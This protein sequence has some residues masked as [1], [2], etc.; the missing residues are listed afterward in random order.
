MLHILKSWPQFFEATLQKRK[1]FELRKNDR[2]YR[3]GDVLRMME[4]KLSDREYSG[5]SIEARVVYIL[6][7]VPGFGLA[8]DHVILGIEM[9]ETKAGN[10]ALEESAQE[11]R[12]TQ[13]SHTM[14]EVKP[15]TTQNTPTA[16]PAQPQPAQKPEVS[17]EIEAKAKELYA[18]IHGSPRWEA[19]EGNKAEFYEKAKQALGSKSGN[20]QGQSQEQPQK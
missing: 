4:Y 15:M 5:R 12:Y 8:M 16:Q 3:V 19:F 7:G 20:P 2:D 14:P 13:W 1:T 11:A 9:L 18:A 17:P 6:D 10:E